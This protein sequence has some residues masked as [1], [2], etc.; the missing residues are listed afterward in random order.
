MGGDLVQEVKLR[1]TPQPLCKVFQNRRFG[2]FPTTEAKKWLSR[3]FVSWPFF[4]GLPQL[5]LPVLPDLE[6]SPALLWAVPLPP[7]PEQ[8]WSPSR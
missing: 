2:W 1:V 8:S 6:Q 3:A 7:Y 5:Q 4:Y